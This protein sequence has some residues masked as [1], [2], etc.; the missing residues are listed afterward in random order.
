MIRAI[1]SWTKKPTVSNG[2]IMYANFDP[3]SWQ[4][5]LTKANGENE[6]LDLTKYG[7]FGL[8]SGALKSPAVCECGRSIWFPGFPPPGAIISFGTATDT[9]N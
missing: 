8:D 7:G 1:Y 9:A 6:A 3:D 2:L 4:L 5:V